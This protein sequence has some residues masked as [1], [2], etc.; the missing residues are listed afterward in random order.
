MILIKG[1]I[2]AFCSSVC[3]LVLDWLG[4]EDEDKS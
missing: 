1:F 4:D 2:F 3:L